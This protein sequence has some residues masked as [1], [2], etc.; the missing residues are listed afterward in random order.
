VSA[1]VVSTDIIKV[2]SPMEC[3]AVSPEG[4]LAMGGGPDSTAVLW[5]VGPATPATPS[6][7]ATLHGHTSIVMAVAFSPDG[8]TLATG[9]DDGT[10]KLW[11]VGS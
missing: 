7:L 10:A 1:D 4:H 6:I 11:A 5:T 3:L 9:S 8:R 2:G